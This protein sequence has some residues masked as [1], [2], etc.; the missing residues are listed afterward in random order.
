MER[1][2]CYNEAG[3]PLAGG[4]AGIFART[5]MVPLG[6]MLIVGVMAASG[7]KITIITS[8]L[9]LLLFVLLALGVLAVSSPY[10]MA[11]EIGRAHV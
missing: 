7:M 1:V 2:R 10:R 9:P 3:Q 6:F 11:R 8:S 4:A 5:L